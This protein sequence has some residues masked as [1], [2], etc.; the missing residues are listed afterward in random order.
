MPSGIVVIIW[1]HVVNP[2]SFLVKWMIDNLLPGKVKESSMGS[3]VQESHNPSVPTV[4]ANAI[5][6]WNLLA[7][8]SPQVRSCAE[9]VCA[10]IREIGIVISI[11]IELPAPGS[12]GNPAKASH[13]LKQ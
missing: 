6:S 3:S 2:L 5:L 12:D 1:R 4:M 7:D 13:P 8:L 9:E 11:A 10:P